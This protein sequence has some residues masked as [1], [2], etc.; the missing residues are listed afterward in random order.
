MR[1]AASTPGAANNVSAHRVQITGGPALA[2]NCAMDAHG[3]PAMLG[4]DAEIHSTDPHNGDDR[5][6]R[7]TDHGA[8]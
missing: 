7:C 6:H 4:R 5:P 8:W 1:R 2:A 3:V